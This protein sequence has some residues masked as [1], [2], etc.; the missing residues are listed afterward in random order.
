MANSPFE[1][2]IQPIWDVCIDAVHVTSNE[3]LRE[4][5][6]IV[7]VNSAF[8]TLSGYSRKDAIGAPATILNG[9]NTA[10]E[11][12][13]MINV[14]LHHGLPGRSYLVCYRKDGSE[15]LCQRAAA[16]LVGIDGI[17]RHFIFFTH[18]THVGYLAGTLLPQLSVADETIALNIPVPLAHFARGKV[19]EHL[20]SHPELDA[21]LALWIEK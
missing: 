8:E 16:P 17:A 11:Q 15:F 9:T 20:K 12:L 2:L 7:Y 4:E 1:N 13:E 14:A 18:Q 5:Q 19:P 21:L 6:K 10:L 3:S